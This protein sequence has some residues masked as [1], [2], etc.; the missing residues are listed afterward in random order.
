MSAH[1]TPQ[2]GRGVTEMKSELW[3][4]IHEWRDTL[5]DERADWIENRINELIVL[6]TTPAAGTGGSVGAVSMSGVAAGMMRSDVFAERL[7]CSRVAEDFMKDHLPGPH[8][9]AA[10]VISARILQRSTDPAN[11]SPELP[12]IHQRNARMVATPAPEQAAPVSVQGVTDA[13]EFCWC[14]ES[15]NSADWCFAADREGVVYN[16]RFLDPSCI[17]GEPFQLFRF[18]SAILSTASPA[19]AG[20]DRSAT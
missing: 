20:T 5:D 11:L 9:Y 15:E 12:Q 6:I 7:A 19:G 18:S 17:R 14:I 13:V 16:A 2:A 10:N 4:L 1:N 3:S 8:W